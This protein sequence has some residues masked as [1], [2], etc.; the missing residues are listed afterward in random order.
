[1]TS[2]QNIRP[3]IYGK[4]DIPLVIKDNC[5]HPKVTTKQ[6]LLELLQEFEQIFDGT[7][8]EWKKSPTKLELKHG[9][10]PVLIWAY[11][12]PIVHKNIF[13]KEIDRL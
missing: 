13:G 1:M 10:L 9:E 8:G 5:N 2:N 11:P 3:Q 6:K 4:V 12:I 7:L